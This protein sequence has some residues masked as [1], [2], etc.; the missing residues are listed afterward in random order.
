MRLAFTTI[1]NVLSLQQ[2]FQPKFLPTANALHKLGYSLYATEGTAAYL[3]A[4]NIPALNV[5]WPLHEES[6]GLPSASR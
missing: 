6:S 2:S 4:H 5:G 1:V 3:K